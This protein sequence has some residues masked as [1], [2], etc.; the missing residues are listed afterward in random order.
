MSWRLLQN[1]C[2]DVLFHSFLHIFSTYS[3]FL[4]L[5]LQQQY[6]A[7]V[8]PSH[9]GWMTMLSKSWLVVH[10]ALQSLLCQR[11][12]NGKKPL[13][14]NAGFSFCGYTI[15]AMLT[16]R[17]FKDVTLSSKCVC[18]FSFVTVW[19]VATDLIGRGNLT[20]V[21]WIQLSGWLDQPVGRH[22]LRGGGSPC[23]WIVTPIKTIQREVI[24]LVVYQDCTCIGH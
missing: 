20:D 11:K 2:D 4:L 8:L 5:S 1:T 21:L 7:Y 12:R 6:C 9:L 19:P 18:V 24:L 13:Q 16:V 23:W 3:R 14:Y 15:Y 10:W 17:V 22:Q